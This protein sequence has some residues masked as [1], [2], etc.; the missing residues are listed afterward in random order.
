MGTGAGPT[1][2]LAGVRRPFFLRSCGVRCSLLTFS[3][4][5]WPVPGRAGDQK[6]ACF[7]FLALPALC[8]RDP[9]GWV[10][11]RDRANG[12]CSGDVGICLDL[13]ISR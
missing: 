2:A 12:T 4:R 1:L 3:P 10:R 5:V 6:G 9:G 11:H 13:R 8:P 7:L